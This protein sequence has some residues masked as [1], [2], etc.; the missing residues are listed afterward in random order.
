[1]Q[2]EFELCFASCRHARLYLYHLNE[3]LNLAFEKQ[4]F[5]VT[6]SVKT[7]KSEITPKTQ[8]LNTKTQILNTKTQILNRG[9]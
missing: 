6:I 4:L 5:I 7:K 2:Y 8:F 1:M 9:K 3:Q